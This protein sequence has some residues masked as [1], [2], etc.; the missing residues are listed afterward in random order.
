MSAWDPARKPEGQSF[1]YYHRWF[2]RTGANGDFETL[3]RLL[4]PKP[5]DP[6]VGI[7]EMDV[8]FPDPKC[9]GVDKPELGGILRLGGALRPPHKVPPEPPDKYETWD[10]RSR[11]PPG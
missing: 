2:F 3:V 1:P 10:S 8:Q 9:A 7:R 5:V 6:R 11:G 4:K